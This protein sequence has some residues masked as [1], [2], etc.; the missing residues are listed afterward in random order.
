MQMWQD[1]LI[2]A[3]LSLFLFVIALRLLKILIRKSISSELGEVVL[4]SLIFIALFI[5]FVLFKF[6]FWELIGAVLV[7]FGYND[8]FDVPSRDNNGALTV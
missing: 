5:A 3:L 1:M 8:D 6:Q 4:Q 7:F 2:Q